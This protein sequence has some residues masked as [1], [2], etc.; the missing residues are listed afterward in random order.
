MR[1]EDKRGITLEDLYPAIL[2]VVLIGVILGIG[3]YVMNQ[4]SENIATNVGTVINESGLGI[5]RTTATVDQASAQGF[6]TFAITICYAN[7]SGSGTRGFANASIVAANYTIDVDLGII[8]N[9]TAL[10]YNDVKCSYTYLFGGEGAAAI[11]TTAS[12][13]GDFADWIAVIVVVIAA[14]IVLGVVLTSFR[15][16]TPGV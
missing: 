1:L 12:G 3:I 2:T 13:V 7:A 6:N 8:R 16:R 5:N 14:A 4:V 11:D 15:R 9:A 10:E